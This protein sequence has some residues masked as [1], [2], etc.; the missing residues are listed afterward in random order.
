MHPG[1]AMGNSP[2]ARCFLQHSAATNHAPSSTLVGGWLPCWSGPVQPLF[3]RGLRAWVVRLLGCPWG[4][5]WGMI[6]CIWPAGV[7]CMSS[8]MSFRKSLAR[9]RSMLYG[10]GARSAL[11]ADKSALRLT[12]QLPNPGTRTQS[13]FGR[14]RRRAQHAPRAAA[15]S[16]GAVVTDHSLHGLAQVVDHAVCVAEVGGG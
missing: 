13:D 11:A 4:C 9:G 12:A 16:G 5:L 7:C 6:A 10:R 1:M 14:V 2:Y 3:D 15:Y 8:A